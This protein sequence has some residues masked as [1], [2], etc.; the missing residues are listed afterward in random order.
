[1]STDSKVIADPAERCEESLGRG[2][3]FES[4]HSSFAHA[5]GLMT[6]FR[7]VVQARCCTD[8]QMLDSIQFV[9]ALLG[10]AVP[11][12]SIRHD[13]IG[14]A[15]HMSKQAAAEALRCIRILLRSVTKPT[16]RSVNTLRITKLIRLERYGVIQSL[17]A[18]HRS[19]EWLD[20]P[21]RSRASDLTFLGRRRA[22]ARCTECSAVRSPLGQASRCPAPAPRAMLR[23]GDT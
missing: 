19:S 5:C 4:L 15:A 8:A 2:H 1:M 7:S 14:R 3:R 16:D 22:R 10:R 13:L 6:L 20:E 9:D 17:P 23:S 21:V 11:R 12:E 18:Q